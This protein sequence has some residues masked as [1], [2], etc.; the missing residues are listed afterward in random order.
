MQATCQS[1]E[2]CLTTYNQAWYVFFRCPRD[3][4]GFPSPGFAGPGNG[5]PGTEVNVESKVICTEDTQKRL[6]TQAILRPTSGQHGGYTGVP[7]GIHRRYGRT[8]AGKSARSPLA[9]GVLSIVREGPAAR[10]ARTPFRQSP[11]AKATRG[12]PH[13]RSPEA[14][15]RAPGCHRAPRQSG[16]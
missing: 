4:R 6:Q 15:S 14:G 13:N 1:G 9:G 10:R 7:P 8:A 3:H 2:I 11:P 12:G 5:K 16:G